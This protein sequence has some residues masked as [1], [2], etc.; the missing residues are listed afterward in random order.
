M[1][2]DKYFGFMRIQDEGSVLE[3]FIDHTLIDEEEIHLLHHMIEAMCGG[4]Y[5]DIQSLYMKIRTIANDSKR[6]YETISDQII[7][8][9]FNHQR[10]YDLLRLQQRIEAISVLIIATAKRILILYRTKTQLPESMYKLL[11]ELSEKTVEIH[12]TFS[13]A[14]TLFTGSKQE[15]IEHIHKIE[16]QENYIDHVRSECL[17]KLYLIGNEGE[18]KMGSFMI[19]QEI[20]EHI[21]D[22]SDKIEES[23]RSLDWLLLS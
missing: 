16:H 23:A 15:V 12:K 17:E 6:I 22:I 20:I 4:K 8:A 11:L 19:I 18:I 21:E 1:V 7:Q 14:L 9:N 13:K 10:Q 5:D 3:L 2:L